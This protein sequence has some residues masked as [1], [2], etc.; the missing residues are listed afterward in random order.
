M[1][2]QKYC[3]TLYHWAQ[4]WI[5]L[6]Q[7]CPLGKRNS[8]QN[9]TLFWLLK[10]A[11]PGPPYIIGLKTVF[12]CQDTTIICKNTLCWINGDLCTMIM[13]HHLVLNEDGIYSL[14][15]PAGWR[16]HLSVWI[17]LWDILWDTLYSQKLNKAFKNW[18]WA[19]ET[20]ETK[21]ILVQLKQWDEPPPMSRGK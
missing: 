13:K 5:N 10:K 11:I 9:H 21:V 3:A 4:V 7:K 19:M 20:L 1:T 17:I 6:W 8:Q 18:Y 15:C 12:Q 2:D 14:W 16:C